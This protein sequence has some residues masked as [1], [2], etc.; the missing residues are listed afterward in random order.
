LPAKTGQLKG[1]KMKKFFRAM[2]PYLSVLTLAVSILFV[3]DA[4]AQGTDAVVSG[5]VL[6]ATGAIVPAATITALNLNT[7]VKT[8]VTSNASGVYLYAA[9]PPGDY[10]FTAEKEGF[11]RLDLNETTLRIGDHLQQNLTLQVG[12]T[13][14]SVQVT[15]NTDSVSYLSASQGGLLNSQRIQDL[16][17]SGRNV[18][19]LVATQAGMVATSSGVNMNGS[20]TDMMNITLDG[21]NI[22]DNAVLE[23]ITGQMI[24]TTVD[25]V[26]EVKVVTSPADAE[27][28]RGSGQVQ[29]V[30]RSGTNKFHGS[31]YDFAHNTDL[32]A[33]SW[34]NN[35]NGLPRSVQVLNQTGARVDGPVRKNKT[36][37]F[38]L[39]EASINRA[40]TSETD[41]VP[42][43]SA[44]QGI[45]RFYPGVQN[46]NANA[47]NPSVD[48]SGNPVTPRGATGGLQ[49]VSL[50]GLDPNRLAPDSTGIVAKNLALMPL[51]NNYLAAGD[52]LNTAA[53]IWQARVPTNIYSLDL[54]V[55]HNF[56]Q[57]ERLTASYNHDTESE[58]NGNDAQN[59]PTSVPGRYQQFS[60]V[61]SLA[62]VSTL[63]PAMVNEARIGV[64]R[65]NLDFEA[66]WTSSS[67]G[68]PACC[69]R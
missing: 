68:T 40:L 5:D 50:F 6:D 67:Q 45:F 11:K 16:P 13:K 38:A 48:L 24:A 8:V 19:E 64:Q 32:N 37:F 47:N 20:R 61:G 41:T 66:P 53:Y 69:P 44:R 21:T 62:L 14:E 18:M 65:T 55:D 1:S 60:T 34:S 49:S 33:N 54:R 7:G 59:Y 42:T 3:P 29:L 30:S 35:R 23:S 57:S 4:W 52:G 36:F 9:L 31:V 12:A 39:F 10:R 17:V 27:Y 15:A 28:G 51:P 22:Q 43:A 2:A 26:E 46:A 63:G 25:R 58:P 56:S